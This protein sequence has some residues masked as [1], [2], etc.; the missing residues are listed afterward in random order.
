MPHDTDA[1][2]G[3][4][5]R[6][7]TLPDEDIDLAEAALALAALERPGRP[8]DGY[9]RF[10]DTLAAEVAGQA[11]AGGAIEDR[12]AAL[13]GI[14]ADRHRFAGDS[15]D[16]EEPDNANLMRV[17]D[18]RR[19]LPVTLGILYLKIGRACGWGMHG[20]GFPL[21]FLIRLDG[22]AGERAILD[23]FHGGA[24]LGAAELRGLL[25]AITGNGAELEPGHYAP[26]G[27][28]DILLRLQNN[29]KFRQLR[30]AQLA[31]ALR[32]VEGMLLFAPDQAAL[33]R[34]AGMMH[35]RLG[36]KANAI[37]A[38]EQFLAR[39]ANAQA[40]HRIGVLLQELRGRCN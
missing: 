36:D 24:R 40:R 27:N 26:V 10:L 5:S 14:I 33:W 37:A 35:L 38:L 6:L 28:R 8:R 13:N 20:L 12:I 3:E 1:I 21:H 9:R 29:V 31:E 34:E 11:G 16:Y 17:I 7:A 23:P 18:R 30:S 15:S 32:T 39:T 22:P 19:G 2:R 4:L 25:K